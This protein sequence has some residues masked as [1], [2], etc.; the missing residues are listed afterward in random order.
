[1]HTWG[2]VGG[3]RRSELALVHVCNGAHKSTRCINANGRCGTSWHNRTALDERGRECNGA[4]ATHGGVTLV[5]HKEHTDL[6][7]VVIGWHEDA[8]VHV[9][10]TAWLPHKHLAQVIVLRQCGAASLKNGVALEFGIAA[11]HNAKRLTGGVIVKH[12]DCSIVCCWR[13]VDAQ[14]RYRSTHRA[15]SVPTFCFSA[16]S[17]SS[18]AYAKSQAEIPR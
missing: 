4:V 10:M 18:S 2:A 17:R 3:A 13:G 9:G 11:H 1:M 16:R 6:R 5:V 7:L 12:L 14:A 15:S 8:A